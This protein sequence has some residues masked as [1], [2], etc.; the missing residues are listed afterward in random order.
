MPKEV[1]LAFNVTHK[2]SNN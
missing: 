2:Y 1:I